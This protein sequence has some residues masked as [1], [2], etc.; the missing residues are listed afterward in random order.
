MSAGN[1]QRKAGSFCFPCCCHRGRETHQEW[2][3]VLAAT[4]SASQHCCQS[5]LLW[6]GVAGRAALGSAT[7]ARSMSRLKRGDDGDDVEGR[8]EER[9]QWLISGDFSKRQKA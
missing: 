2:Q 1:K 7:V 6:A 9:K 8:K 5:S 4:A 3:E